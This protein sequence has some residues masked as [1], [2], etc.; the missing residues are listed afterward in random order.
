MILAA[1]VKRTAVV[2]MDIQGDD[3]KD[4]RFPR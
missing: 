4:E 1:T 3:E 2:V